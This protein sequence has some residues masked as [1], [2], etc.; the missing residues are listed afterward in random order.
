MKEIDH[1]LDV[2]QYLVTEK[3]AY[4][5]YV[6]PSILNLVDTDEINN[7][8]ADDDSNCYAADD[9]GYDDCTTYV[10]GGSIYDD[11]GLIY[12]ERGQ[13]CDEFESILDNRLTYALDKEPASGVGAISEEEDDDE[14]SGF[15]KFCLEPKEV[16]EG[17]MCRITGPTSLT[18]VITKIGGVDLS[19]AKDN[20]CKVMQEKCNALPPLDRIIPG[21][22]CKHTT[23]EGMVR[24]PTR[25][26]ANN[27]N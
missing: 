9:N 13:T 25:L 18:L 23:R 10:D 8:D 21:M 24:L 1:N 2:L 4:F 20:M 26:G 5:E 27:L 11:G 17:T 14:E 7:D 19:V 22:K 15:L 3:K 16:I 6:S 12:N